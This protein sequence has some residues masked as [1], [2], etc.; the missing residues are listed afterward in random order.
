MCN[1]F[2]SVII[3]HCGEA[4]PNRKNTTAKGRE[5]GGDP[6]RMRT[7]SR[8]IM[9]KALKME[10]A[11]ARTRFRQEEPRPVS[12]VL[13]L[14]THVALQF[15]TAQTLLFCH[16]VCLAGAFL[17]HYTPPLFAEKPPLNNAPHRKLLD[18]CDAKTSRTVPLAREHTP[19]HPSPRS[20]GR[21][22]AKY[23]ILAQPRLYVPNQP[24]EI[25][26]ASVGLAGSG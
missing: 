1:V 18:W 16:R 13:R 25:F 4:G 9:R 6:Q 3:T 20:E 21:N 8:G 12:F 15:C 10:T 2:L 19:V 26:Q 14:V 17:P 23:A 22:T 7:T 11:P 24:R 5:E